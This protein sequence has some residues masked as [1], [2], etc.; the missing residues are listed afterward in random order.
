M[1]FVDELKIAIHKDIEGTIKELD[2]PEMMEYCR[3]DF[4]TNNNDEDDSEPTL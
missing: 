3:N 1:Y 2:K 4:F